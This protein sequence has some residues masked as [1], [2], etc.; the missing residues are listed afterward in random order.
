MTK[1]IIL[2]VIIV[3]ALIFAF[4]KYMKDERL[5]MW[6]AILIAILC[7]SV[8]IPEAIHVANEYVKDKTDSFF[9]Q[10]TK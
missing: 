3:L 1:L 4:V 2:A 6:F 5:L 10:L 8:A 9:N 7:L